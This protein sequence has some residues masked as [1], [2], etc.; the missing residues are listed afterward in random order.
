MGL[1]LLLEPVKWV[2]ELSLRAYCKAGDIFE[3]ATEKSRYKLALYLGVAN[4]GVAFAYAL[5]LISANYDLIF[6]EGIQHSTT[7][8]IENLSNP[9]CGLLLGNLTYNDIKHSYKLLKTKGQEGSE[10]VLDRFNEAMGWIN[11]RVRL[12]TLAMS[13][14]LA[15][16]TVSDF[17]DRPLLAALEL[18]LTFILGSLASSIYLKGKDEEILKKE[19]LWTRAYNSL[20]NGIEKLRPQTINTYQ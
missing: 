7:F 6:P 1:E 18:G 4:I 17:S 11:K 9:I 12:P 14:Y 16:Q 19:P 10:K 15:N 13:T 20:S 3:E 5:P 8:H 2:D